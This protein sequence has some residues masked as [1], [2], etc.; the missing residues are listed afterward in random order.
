M[1]ERFC[2]NHTIR[3]AIMLNNFNRWF[4]LL[5]LLFIFTWAASF[6]ARIN[7]DRD[8]VRSINNCPYWPPVLTKFALNIGFSLA[9]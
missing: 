2:R 7:K 5:L 4:S 8:M 3:Q 6:T 1:K 9:Q